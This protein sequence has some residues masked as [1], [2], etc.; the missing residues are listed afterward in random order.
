MS[1]F[2]VESGESA[3]TGVY[4]RRIRSLALIMWDL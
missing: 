3:F 4:Y 2:W 1:Q